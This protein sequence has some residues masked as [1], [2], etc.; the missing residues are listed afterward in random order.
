MIQINDEYVIP[1]NMKI[2]LLCMYL[3]PYSDK[4]WNT[5]PHVILTSEVEWDPSVLDLDIDDNQ[6]WFDAISD[7]P[8]CPSLQLFDAYGDYLKRVEV[9]CYTR[10]DYVDHCVLY[11]TN[12]HITYDNKSSISSTS[13]ITDDFFDASPT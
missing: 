2:A 7:D 5:L 4:E 6:E 10:S 12:K 11:H 3:R 9:N 1:L 8:D 13:D